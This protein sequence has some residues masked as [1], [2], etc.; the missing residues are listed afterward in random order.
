MN[1]FESVQKF[2]YYPSFLQL[3]GVLVAEGKTTGPVQSESL[4]YYTKLNLQRLQRWEKTFHLS[5]TLAA[6]AKTAKPQIWWLITE[7]WCGDA[8]QT[9]MVMNSMALQ[10][11]GKID[12]RLIMRDDNPTIMDY[13]LTNGSRSIPIL[14]AMDM[15]GNELFHWGP[16]PKPAQQMMI[17]WKANPDSKTMDDV[18]R[19]IHTWYTKDKGLTAEQELLQLIG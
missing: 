12:L 13:Y 15:E 17:D 16:R 6:K 2:Y 4:I 9:L 5:E 10:S 11:E 14:V 1:H 3:M 8:A 19:D 18:E 7:A